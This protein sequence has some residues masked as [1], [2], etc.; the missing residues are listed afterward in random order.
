MWVQETTVRAL[1]SEKCIS[2]NPECVSPG[3]RDQVKSSRRND[4]LSWQ[5]FARLVVS[6]EADYRFA[7]V[8][9]CVAMMN[10]TAAVFWSYQRQVDE[11]T[12]ASI[13]WCYKADSSKHKRKFAWSRRSYF[14]ARQWS[15]TLTQVEIKYAQKSSRVI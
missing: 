8:R 14:S 6:Y 12:G 7:E 2:P 13:L 3:E 11:H 15:C 4:K 1:I 10:S 9:R 5:I